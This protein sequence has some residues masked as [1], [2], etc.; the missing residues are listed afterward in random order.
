MPPDARLI[1]NRSVLGRNIS[2]DLHGDELLKKNDRI[3]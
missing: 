1:P 2:R 3:C